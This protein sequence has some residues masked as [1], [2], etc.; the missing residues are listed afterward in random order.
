MQHS[1][2]LDEG[3]KHTL[4]FKILIRNDKPRQK[5]QLSRLQLTEKLT[6]SHSL[7]E[8][9]C[10]V[11]P[12]AA[13]EWHGGGR[14]RL[15]AGRDSRFWRYYPQNRGSRFEWGWDWENPVSGKIWKAYTQWQPMAFLDT[16]N[17]SWLQWSIGALWR[18]VIQML[19]ARCWRYNS[20]SS[21]LFASSPPP[22]TRRRSVTQGEFVMFSHL[23]I[24]RHGMTRV[25]LVLVPFQFDKHVALRTLDSI[26]KLTICNQ[27]TKES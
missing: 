14:Q 6:V 7:L 22:F 20:A 11:I 8:N 10:V 1:W 3:G 24:S 23:S 9:D 21:P 17:T 26:F 15:S 19:R 12:Q 25:L 16:T 18:L 13:G 4:P 2:W 27:P 5:E